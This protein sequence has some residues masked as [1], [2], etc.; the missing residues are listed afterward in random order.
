MKK[1]IFFALRVSCKLHVFFAPSAACA[2]VDVIREGKAIVCLFRASRFVLA[3]FHRSFFCGTTCLQFPIF[4]FCFFFFYS[5][6]S[7]V[8]DSSYRRNCYKQCFFLY[9]RHLQS[10]PTGRIIFAFNGVAY[11]SDPRFMIFQSI[12]HYLFVYFRSRLDRSV[13]LTHEIVYSYVQPP[14]YII[15]FIQPLGFIEMLAWYRNAL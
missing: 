3:S 7:A 9:S 6:R 11:M 14:G 8:T 5:L 4:C 2:R 15:L 10:I 13:V 1:N 12:T